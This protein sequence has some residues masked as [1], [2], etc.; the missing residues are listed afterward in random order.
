MRLRGNAVAVKTWTI[1]VE[2]NRH[3]VG[4]EHGH[5]YILKIRHSPF[6]YDYEFF[7]DGKLV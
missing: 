3:S 2:G 6:R 5:P 1:D 7:L 4:I